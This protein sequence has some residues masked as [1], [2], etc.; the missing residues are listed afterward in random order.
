M[1]SHP[2][3][4]Q[5]GSLTKIDGEHGWWITSQ[6]WMNL[7][8]FGQKMDGESTFPLLSWPLSGGEKLDLWPLIIFHCCC[9]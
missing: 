1:F 5:G 7:H 6:K 2:K 3:H 4:E 9:T 8:L